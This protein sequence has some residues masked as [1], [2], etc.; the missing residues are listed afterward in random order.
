MP[1][2]WYAVPTE[3][4]DYATEIYRLIDEI[5]R[6]YLYLADYRASVGKYLKELADDRKEY[7]KEYHNPFAREYGLDYFFPLTLSY[8]LIVSIFLTLESQFRVLTNI[9]Y[10][11]STVSDGFHEYL[12]KTYKCGNFEKY[13]HYYTDQTRVSYADLRYWQQINKLSMLR[14]CIVHVSGYIADSRKRSEI[15]RM[16]RSRDYLVTEDRSQPKARY[17]SDNYLEQGE[18][19]IDEFEERL[20]IGGSYCKTACKY[21][22]G[23]VLDA[24]TRAGVVFWARPY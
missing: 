5:E 7:T 11:K 21:C 4:D 15:E 6:D 13:L 8:A 19:D 12:R 16:V 10:D 17:Q 14:D 1:S 23:F 20:L 9:I 24:I 3:Y 22:E 2:E 18:I